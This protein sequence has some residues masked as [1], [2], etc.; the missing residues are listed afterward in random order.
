MA[1]RLAIL[2]ILQTA[3]ANVETITVDDCARTAWLFRSTFC[4]D[5]LKGRP[6]DSESP[7][8]ESHKQNHAAQSA[9]NPAA[10]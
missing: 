7:L 10:A 9:G 8:I 5:L 6:G 3:F 4:D 1:Q 2:M